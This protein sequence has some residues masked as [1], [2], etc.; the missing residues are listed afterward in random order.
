[1][2]A[3]EYRRYGSPEVLTVTDV[4]KPNP[5][6]LEVLVRVRATTVTST[7]GMMRRGDTLHS[8]LVLGLWRPRKRFRIQGLE[9]AGDVE[10]VGPRVSRFAPGDRVFG[11]TGFSLGAHAE[12]CCLPERSSLALIPADTSYEE[13]AAT[14]DGATTALF[15]LRKAGL[16]PGKKVLVV[17]ASGSIGTAAVQIAKHGGAEVTG[18]CSAANGAFVRSLG[19]EDVIDYARQ[20]FAASGKHWDIIFD[21]VNRSSFAQSRPALNDGG[22]YVPTVGG[23]WYL[24][25]T[26]WTHR[27]AR[28]RLFFG[29]S[30]DKREEIEQVSELLRTGALRPVIDR[31]YALE[32]VAL[33]HRYAE[34]GHKRGNVVISI[35]RGAPM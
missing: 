1:M 34:G 15:F 2:K 7:E 21:T 4:P 33:A 16:E 32:E 20:D 30:I 35:G 13:A 29:M 10:A 11:F 5:G 3:I 18:V 26:A 6:P 28:K 17:G 8:R 12:Y 9:V 19:A 23:L 14:V 22:C 31:R 27:F 24:L 25:L